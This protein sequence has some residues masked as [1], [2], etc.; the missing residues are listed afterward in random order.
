MAFLKT[1]SVAIFLCIA[2]YTGLV[3]INHGANL[4]PIFV[5]DLF[6]LT[7][8]GQFNL[9]FS[10]YLALSALWVAWRHQF[11]TQGIAVGLIACVAGML[12]FAPYL[13][14]AIGKADGDFK[15]LLMGNQDRS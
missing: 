9:D 4:I 14:F 6:S 10:G 3:V 15:L 11:S 12:F 7:W 5:G 1:L 8:R 2:I 13:F